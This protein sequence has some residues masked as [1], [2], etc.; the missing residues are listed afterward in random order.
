MPSAVPPRP[1]ASSLSA[2]T[3]TTW[4]VKPPSLLLSSLSSRLCRQAQRTSKLPSWHPE[5]QSR[6]YPQKKSRP[7]SR[8]LRQ[9][10]R[11]SKPRRSPAEAV[12]VPAICQPGQLTRARKPFQARIDGSWRC[13][14]ALAIGV[15]EG[16]LRRAGR[17][18]KEWNRK[19]RDHAAALRL[20]VLSCPT[21]HS[22]V[23]SRDAVLVSMPPYGSVD[24][25]YISGP[26]MLADRPL[27]TC[28]VK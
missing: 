23:M 8:P 1:F 15:L 20:C 26:Q 24:S 27:P 5:R 17:S 3:K 25:V 4:I 6:C 2:T 12:K 19:R 22:R 16:P 14:C 13:C 10:S 28:S 9:R 21:M 11:R 7:T 18:T